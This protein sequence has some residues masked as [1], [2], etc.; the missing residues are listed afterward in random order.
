L[1][2]KECQLILV[3]ASKEARK[4]PT[5][6]RIP[7]AAA[8]EPLKA[9]TIRCF[10]EKRKATGMIED[11]QGKKRAKH[12]IQQEDA[13]DEGRAE[14]DSATEEEAEGSKP[15]MRKCAASPIAPNED[16]SQSKGRQPNRKA[17]KSKQPGEEGNDVK[18][19]RRSSR[20]ANQV[21]QD[22]PLAAKS[23]AI[24]TTKGKEAEL[25][26]RSKAD[27]VKV[28][29][30][31]KYNLDAFLEENVPEQTQQRNKL[32]SRD[33]PDDALA[34][35]EAP[36]REHEDLGVDEF[37][38]QTFSACGGDPVMRFWSKGRRRRLEEGI[39]E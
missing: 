20:I 21:R 9:I 30:L 5:I 15:K 28:A 38:P 10:R 31:F 34:F 25:D 29:K 36:K 39:V 7:R 8:K 19:L 6:A 16:A 1:Y 2:R 26:K 3:Q 32:V 33:I 17:M 35:L 22:N 18:T 23:I 27:T 24:K 37:L 14:D 12:G 13:E 4:R 11:G